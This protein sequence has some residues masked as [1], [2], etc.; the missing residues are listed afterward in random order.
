MADNRDYDFLL[1][2]AQHLEQ[3]GSEGW[4]ARLTPWLYSAQQRVPLRGLMFSQADARCCLRMTNV[5]KVRLSLRINM[6]NVPGDLA[7]DH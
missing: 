3:G 1:R 4:K 7:G 5:L 6:P 2:L